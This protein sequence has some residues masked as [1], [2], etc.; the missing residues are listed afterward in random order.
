[1]SVIKLL[2]LRAITDEGAAIEPLYKHEPIRYF[3]L[4]READKFGEVI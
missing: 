3:L 4:Q 1:M 2:Q